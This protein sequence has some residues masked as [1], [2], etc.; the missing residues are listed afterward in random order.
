MNGTVER[1]IL[2]RAAAMRH[3]VERVILT[4][5]R[6]DAETDAEKE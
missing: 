2:T 6:G 4:R 1:V 5:R 3:R